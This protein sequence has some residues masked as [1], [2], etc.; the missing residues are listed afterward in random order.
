MVSLH[1]NRNGCTTDERNMEGPIDI[2][3]TPVDA[4]LSSW[5]CLHSRSSYCKC[6]YFGKIR[7]TVMIGKQW[8]PCLH[9]SRM[10]GLC[11]IL[12]SKCQEKSTLMHHRSGCSSG[13]K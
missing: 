10:Q 13:T 8:S 6:W 5:P 9:T 4:A 1:V 12:A 3:Q 7:E 2:L 11:A